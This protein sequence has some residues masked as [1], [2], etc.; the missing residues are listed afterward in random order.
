MSL[1]IVGAGMAGLL[2]ANMLK[3]HNPVVVETQ[4]ALPNNHHA[5]L[6][7]SSPLVGEKLG[8]PF[9]KVTLVKHAIEWRNQVA[10]ILAYAEK[11]TGCLT[12]ERSVSRRNV[13]VA[14]RW[15]AP[16]DL[17]NQ[18]AERVDLHCG[19][20]WDF[21]RTDAGKV[22]STIP[23][24]TLMRELN[25]PKKID[26]RYRHGWVLTAEIAG[27]CD[28]FATLLVPNPHVTFYR[29]SIT[30]RQL[31][32]E[33]IDEPMEGT[34]DVAAYMFCAKVVPGSVIKRRQQYAKILPIDDKERREF[35]YWASSKMSK[36]YSLGRYATW[37]PTLQTDDLV[38]DVRL[39]DGWIREG[40]GAHY[41]MELHEAEK[42]HVVN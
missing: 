37:R 30:G 34:A 4:S 20:V 36:A 18:M 19:R 6:R 35:I 23:M 10:D 8:I 2:A 40:G 29:A 14:E 22:L 11:A 7:F 41:D 5:V 3:H 38:K 1:V 21:S 16:P 42:R 32:V 17:I 33:S 26:F 24:P 39:I 15:I 9:R 13:E 25:Y 12:T 28:A 27:D 31:I